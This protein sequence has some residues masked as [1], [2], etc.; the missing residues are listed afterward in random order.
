LAVIATEPKELTVVN[1][2]GKIDLDQLSDLGG[3]FSIP[4]MELEKSK[5]EPKPKTEPK[6][7]P[8]KKDEE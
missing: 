3:N 5:P 6:P 4:N 7:K 8:D 2:V 1:I